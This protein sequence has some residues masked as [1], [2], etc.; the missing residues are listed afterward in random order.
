MY[1]PAG[2]RAIIYALIPMITLGISIALAIEKAS[3]KRFI[4]IA[5]GLVAM[6]IMLLP[7]AHVPLP[8]E[9][10]WTA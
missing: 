4:G 6:L 9:L 3:L 10:F 2:N 5:L 1:L 7:G 8:Y